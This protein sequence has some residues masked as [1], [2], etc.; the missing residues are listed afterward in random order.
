MT[1][2][3]LCSGDGTHEHYQTDQL[4]VNDQCDVN[5]M[6]NPHSLFKIFKH[7]NIRRP[8][9]NPPV[10]QLEGSQDH[11]H[12]V[13]NTGEEGIVQYRLVDC[14]CISCT[15]HHGECQEKNYADPWI[16][17]NLLPY[18]KKN[19]SQN[20]KFQNGSNLYVVM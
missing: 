16:T 5:V 2:R 17:V 3:R 12:A 15:T 1:D 14:G 8:K 9:G 13:R 19:I 10:R 18:K 4:H 20:L 11:M 7:N 6:K